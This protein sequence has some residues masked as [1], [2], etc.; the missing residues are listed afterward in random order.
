M[1]WRIQY[2]MRSEY[3]YD[4]DI[5]LLFTDW[6]GNLYWL[7]GNI[8][9]AIH[10]FQDLIISQYIYF[11]L[12]IEIGLYYHQHLKYTICNVCIVSFL[13]FYNIRDIYTRI[14]VHVCELFTLATVSCLPW[15]GMNTY[16][17]VSTSI[18]L[19]IWRY[20]LQKW[21]K[22]TYMTTS[23]W[24]IMP[25][26]VEIARV[27]CKYTHMSHVNMNNKNITLKYNIY[28]TYSTHL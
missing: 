14:L 15:Q 26:W 16:R 5:N 23:W 13:A 2:T 25:I 3:I 19:P 9:S 7:Y 1:F 6:N 21:Y 12:R 27:K 24:K 17:I 4:Y 22:T 10:S 8:I 20:I 28:N 11:L 18:R